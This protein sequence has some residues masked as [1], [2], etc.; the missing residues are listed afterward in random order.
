MD[1]YTESTDRTVVDYFLF[2]L[3]FIAFLLGLTGVIIES[4]GVAFAGGLILVL[5]IAAFSARRAPY[6]RTG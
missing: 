5:V 1:P 4:V 2:A 3:G 6:Q